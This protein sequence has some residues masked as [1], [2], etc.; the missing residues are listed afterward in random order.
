MITANIQE[1]ISGKGFIMVNKGLAKAV[2]LTAAA[3]YGELVSTF[4]YWKERGQLTEHEGK[5]WFFCTIEDLE[6][7]T[8]IKKDAQNKAIKVLEKEGLIETKRFGLPAKRYFF[9]T[10]KY[11][12]ILLDNYFSEKPKTDNT[13]DLNVKNADE[14]RYNQISEKPKTRILENRKQD[15]G[16]TDTNKKE[17]NKKDLIKEE[18]EEEE[19]KTGL[20][21]FLLSKDITPENAVMF[22]NALIKENLTGYTND[23]IIKAIE[24]SLNDFI[25][26]VCNE[27]YVWAAG[28]LKRILDS[29]IKR[30]S[31]AGTARKESIRKEILPDWF[32]E[33]EGRQQEQLERKKLTPEEIEKNKKEIAEK[34][35]QLRA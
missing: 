3:I 29:K 24:L 11:I 22:E 21:S 2:G 23:D 5:Q 7:K 26:G 25:N 31:S 12:Q 35:K 18:E 34:L 16:K 20:I 15:F 17:L 27:P 28:K 10:D 8:T 13:N 1:L 19:K 9:I 6:D 32:K 4:L 30:S 33:N 14:P